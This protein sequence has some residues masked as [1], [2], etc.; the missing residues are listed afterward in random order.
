M[1]VLVQSIK[2][3]KELQLNGVNE[4]EMKCAVETNLMFIL[5]KTITIDFIATSAA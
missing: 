5:Q 1:N 4:F 2:S 3:L